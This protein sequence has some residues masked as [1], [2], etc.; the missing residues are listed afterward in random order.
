MNGHLISFIW[1]YKV[2][3]YTAFFS[4]NGCRENTNESS[5][6]RLL[7]LQ[8]KTAAAQFHGCSTWLKRHC[9]VLVCLLHTKQYVEPYSVFIAFLYFDNSFYYF[10]ELFIYIKGKGRVMKVLTDID[11]HIFKIAIMRVKICSAFFRELEEN[12][13]TVMNFVFSSAWCNA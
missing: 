9:L 7:N 1:K 12:Y 2:N 11:G 6:F 3:V 5:F 13:K 10:P 8:M 4:T